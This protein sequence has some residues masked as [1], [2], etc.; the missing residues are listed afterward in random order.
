MILPKM[1]GATIEKKK[2]LVDAENIRPKGLLWG[3]ER[4]RKEV[5]EEDVS[6]SY[7]RLPLPAGQQKNRGACNDTTKEVRAV[8]HLFLQ[9]LHP[10]SGI[11]SPRFIYQRY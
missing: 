6:I 1:V 9:K 4:R 7:I 11:S 10:P 2:R 3:V 8:A 5:S